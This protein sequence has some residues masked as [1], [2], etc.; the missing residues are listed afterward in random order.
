MAYAIVC[1]PDVLLSIYCL[2]LSVV[3]VNVSVVVLLVVA[4]VCHLDAAVMSLLVIAVILSPS[5]FVITL[6]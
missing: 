3:I 6:S 2:S 1:H 4:A 5:F